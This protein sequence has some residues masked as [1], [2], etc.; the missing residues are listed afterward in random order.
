MMCEHKRT[1][2]VSAKCSDCFNMTMTEDNVQTE[3]SGY[4]PCDIG[5]GGG[6]YIEFNYCLDCGKIL[7]QTFPVYPNKDKFTHY[8]YRRTQL[9][10]LGVRDG[11]KIGNVKEVLQTA[12]DVM[13]CGKKRYE[14]D[15]YWRGIVDGINQQSLSKVA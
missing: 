10:N 2:S 3:Q 8:Q 5:I 4:V 12:Y 15:A 9:Y 14:V 1:N 6:D 11:I 13:P 7:E